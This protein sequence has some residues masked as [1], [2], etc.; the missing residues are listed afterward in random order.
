MMHKTARYLGFAFA[1]SDLLLEVGQDGT[2]RF[3]AGAVQA[4]TGRGEEDLLGQPLVDILAAADGRL[5]LRLLATLGENERLEP[6]LIQVRHPL[7]GEVPCIMGAYQIAGRHSVN[8]TFA[9]LAARDAGP[10]PAPASVDVETGLPG[11]DTFQRYVAALDGRANQTRHLTLIRLA[12]LREMCAGMTPDAVSEMMAEIGAVLRQHA[13]SDAAV[14]RLGADRFGMLHGDNLVNLIKAE[15]DAVIRALVPDVDDAIIDIQTLDTHGLGLTMPDRVRV[16]LH[17]VRS[18][19]EQEL[20]QLDPTSGRA[21]IGAIVKDTVRQ[22]MSLRGDLRGGRIKVAYQPIV[23]LRTGRSH[24]LEALARAPDGTSYAS[25]VAFAE[26]VGVATE[27]DL[28]VCQAVLRDLEQAPADCK[29][30]VNLSGHSIESDL[31]VATL[32]ELLRSRPRHRAQILFELTETVSLRDINRAAR[33]FNDLRDAG[34]SICLDDFGVG[35]ASFPYLRD[36]RFD[37]VKLDGSY[38]RNLGRSERDDAIL[39][40]MMRLCRQLK[41]RTIAEHV[42]TPEQVIRL[43]TLKCDFAQG[44]LFGEATKQIEVQHFDLAKLNLPS[45][46]R[47]PLKIG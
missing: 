10:E 45:Q 35:A 29:V 9:R 43:R 6:R 13:P 15:I 24:H 41:V 3:V 26:Q 30:A 20:V 34:H 19:A 8:V 4:L 40:S 7:A 11:R 25:G 18:F 16:L 27:L 47:R 38:I 12:Q 5:V 2:I 31:F 33:I 28:F 39:A 17:V 46:W 22:M 32:L 36:L 37:Y 23:D 14:A 42:E 1:N 44:W 21:L